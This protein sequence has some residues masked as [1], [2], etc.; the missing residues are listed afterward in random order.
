M[1][2]SL[3]LIFSF[4]LAQN[5]FE[6]HIVSLRENGKISIEQQIEIFENA[7]K[8]PENLSDS[9]KEILR[10]YPVKPAQATMLLVK[11]FQMRMKLKKKADYSM[12]D[13]L[14]YYLDSEIYP[15][16]VYY[17]SE[18]D[19]DLAQAVLTAADYS[20]SVEVDEFGFYAPPV[21]T[22]ENR[23]RIYIANTGMGGG[24]YTA[25]ISDYPD[26][27]RD[28]CV[29]YI[30]IDP[31]NDTYSADGVTAHELNHA[32]QASMDC[33]ETTSFWENTATWVMLAVY[34]ESGYYVHYFAEPFQSNPWMS[35]SDGDGND[36]YWYGG[37]L[38]PLWLTEHYTGDYADGNFVR[39]IWE[40]S[41][42]ESNFTNNSATYMD[43]IAGILSSNYG[44]T[45]TEAFRKFNVARY[46]TAEKYIAGRTDMPFAQ[47]MYYSPPVRKSLA[48]DVPVKESPTSN[49]PK[50]F[51]VNYFTL[52]GGTNYSRETVIELTPSRDDELWSMQLIGN[53]PSVEIIRSAP[54]E[55]G[56]TIVY[57]PGETGDALLI[58]ERG[59]GDDFNPDSIGQGAPY[60]LDIYPA[61]PIPEITLILPSTVPNRSEQDI[62]IYGKNFTEDSQ[63]EFGPDD[64]ISADC[65][66]VDS[67][68][69]DCHVEIGSTTGVFD[70][71]VTNDIDT[72]TL[73]GGLTITDN[74]DTETGGSD[75]CSCSSSGSRNSS[76]SGFIMIFSIFFIITIRR[77]L[78]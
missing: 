75:G 11:A 42:Q 78:P 9:H 14:A 57:N 25:P 26:T 59:G 41:I 63:V 22:P 66:Y 20:W 24:G 68:R 72:A 47:D 69:F 45:L 46:Y 49:L 15:I 74:P 61:V 4:L 77:F 50:K 18:S 70:V 29:T 65:T 3:Y 19:L 8:N 55:T 54:T 7:V 34:P 67:S 12:P 51:G 71:I 30:V 21:V 64:E 44:E 56:H 40:D 52:S 10:K 27:P 58:I 33:L 16:R 38:W 6:S 32:M 17:S 35:L 23:Y 37:Y 13:E 1:H 60:D 2:I 28:D 48:I 73:T 76:D 5:S 39:Q 53:S 36:Y 43:A 31:S 62:A